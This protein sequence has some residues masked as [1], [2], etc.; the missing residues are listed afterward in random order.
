MGILNTLRTGKA[1][2]SRI[3]F[4]V[5]KVGSARGIFQGKNIP[6]I[7]EFQID[8]QDGDKLSLEMTPEQCKNAIES[9]TYTYYAIY[10]PIK[11]RNYGG[12]SL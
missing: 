4:P 6:P 12:F 1:K 8:T 3:A 2:S 5:E 9:L 10:P 11:N 7:V